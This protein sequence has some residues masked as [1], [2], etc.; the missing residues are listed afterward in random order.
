MP[1][2][3]RR[4][5]KDTLGLT[6]A[7]VAIFPLADVLDGER[8]CNFLGMYGLNRTKK[9]QGWKDRRQE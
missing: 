7:F 5:A 2:R 3:H 6:A 1:Q 4:S 9:K 8:G